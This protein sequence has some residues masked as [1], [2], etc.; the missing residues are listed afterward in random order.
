MKCGFYEF[1][2]TPPM[3]SIIPGSF[4]A[5]YCDDVL[6]KIYA[7]AFVAQNDDKLVAL[8]VIDACGITFDITESIRKRTTELVPIKED[9][10]MI[11]ATHTHGGGPTLNWGE[12]VVTDEYYLDFLA[13]RTADAIYIAWKRLADSDI[14][15]GKGEINDISFIRIY[16]M[17]DG[18]LK[19]NP[20][21]KSIDNID[22]PTTTIDPEVIVMGVKQGEKMAGAVVNFA[23]HPATIFTD[24]ITGDYISI[25][26]KEMKRIY[27]E[28]FVTV[29]INGA[30]G[31][32]NHVNLYGKPKTP[33]ETYIHVG[34]TIAEKS[35]E[36]LSNADIMTDS[37]IETAFANAEL[38][39]RKPTAEELTEAKKLFDSYGDSLIESTPTGSDP[40]YIN[41][42]FALQKF[43]IMADKRTVE[44][45][46]VQLFRIGSLYIAGTPTQIFTEFGKA[47]KKNIGKPCMVSA[48]AND[49]LGYVPTPECMVEGVYEARLAPTSGLDSDS[50]DRIVNAI[51]ELYKKLNA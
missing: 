41:M 27:G 35:A 18:T 8:A 42:F 38:R 43:I 47:I 9:D 31:N 46:Y 29:F 15:I 25:L 51:T 34:K 23:T 7:R 11:M 49:Y 32:I 30:C 26:S 22:S 28:E 40:N 6:D 13:K 48:F 44:D 4:G 50:G 19:T 3:G 17:K 1:D 37:C 20:G 45:A 16:H 5:R 10:I 39:L 21:R 2:I 14:L 24:Q 33:T 12:E 36:I